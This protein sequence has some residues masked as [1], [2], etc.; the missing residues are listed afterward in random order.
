IRIDAGVE[1]PYQ[2]SFSFDPRDMAIAKRGELVTAALTIVRAYMTAGTPG[3]A[4]SMGSFEDWSDLV[5]SSLMWLGMGDCC[6]DMAAMQSEDPEKD[7][8][9]EVIEVLPRYDFTAR[10]VKEQA[11]HGTEL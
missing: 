4:K 1:N 10:H 11:K 3:R 9:L 5:R 2:R 7:G 6:E 8:L